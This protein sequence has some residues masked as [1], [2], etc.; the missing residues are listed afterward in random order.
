MLH[1][2]DCINLK[3][4]DND[5]STEERIDNYLLGHMSDAERAAF[6]RELDEDDS[7]REEYQCQR[8]VAFAVQKAAMKDFLC[9]HSSEPDADLST[10]RE[11]KRGGNPFQRKIVLWAFVSAAAVVVAIVGGANYLSTFNSIRGAGM[12]AYSEL[13]A[14]VARGGDEVDAMM[15]K[16]YALIG[17]NQCDAALALIDEARGKVTG[18]FEGLSGFDELDKSEAFSNLSSAAAE[19]KLYECRMLR[20]KLYVL[21]WYEAVALMRDGKVI[22]ARKALRAIADS[23]SPYSSRADEALTQLFNK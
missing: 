14:P 18:L 23:D 13:A 4:M 2:F 6:E 21:D 12:E 1:N 9:K 16:I 8:E 17:E 19:E 7:L 5:I 3:R 15:E 20:Q 10:R 22:K 11:R